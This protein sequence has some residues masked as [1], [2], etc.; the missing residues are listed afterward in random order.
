MPK[1]GAPFDQITSTLGRVNYLTKST[2]SYCVLLAGRLNTTDVGNA[3]PMWKAVAL[4]TRTM[5]VKSILGDVTP[6]S[7]YQSLVFYKRGST[8][9]SR[10]FDKPITR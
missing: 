1:N 6:K 5:L 7:L 10:L 4:M 9:C 3:R 2:D 8:L